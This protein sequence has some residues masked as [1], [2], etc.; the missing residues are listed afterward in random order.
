MNNSTGTGMESRFCGN[1]AAAVM[2]V[3]P[4]TEEGTPDGWYHLE[5]KRYPVPAYSGG[6]CGVRSGSKEYEETKII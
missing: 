2:T 5:D 4:E 1:A 6:G 3:R